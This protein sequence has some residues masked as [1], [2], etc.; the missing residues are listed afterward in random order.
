[1][2]EQIAGAH[3]RSET[4]DPGAQSTAADRCVHVSPSP[5]GGRAPTGGLG[6]RREAPAT[7]LSTAAGPDR[8][9]HPLPSGARCFS[10]GTGI[11]RGCGGGT[12]GGAG[13]GACSQ[14]RSGG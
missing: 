14:L 4:R 3:A 2:Q 7:P 6:P 12:E 8:A 13:G 9:P 5:R 1:M 11:G 10:A